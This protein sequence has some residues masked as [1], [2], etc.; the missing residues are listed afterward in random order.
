[1]DDK[2]LYLG[3]CQG[4][5]ALQYHMEEAYLEKNLDTNEA[6][7]CPPIALFSKKYY[8]EINELNNYKIYDFCFIGL[9]SK[10]NVPLGKI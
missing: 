8:N 9:I 6:N 7:W 1:M 10:A 5:M 2:E 3:W 4:Y